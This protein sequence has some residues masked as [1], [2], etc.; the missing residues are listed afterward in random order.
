MVARRAHNPEVGGS[1]PP[2]ATRLEDLHKIVKIFCLSRNIHCIV[3]LRKCLLLDLTTH[4]TFNHMNGG[5][6]GGM[7]KADGPDS[8]SSSPFICGFTLGRT[9]SFEVQIESYIITFIISIFMKHGIMRL[10]PIRI[11]ADRAFFIY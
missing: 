6:S 8:K 4:Y 5:M 2:S 9:R 7:E 3:R 1:S 11:T 10:R